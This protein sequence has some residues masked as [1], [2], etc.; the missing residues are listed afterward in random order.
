MRVVKSEALFAS[1][2]LP[3]LILGFGIIVRCVQYLANRSLWLDE[4]ML[5]LNITH[6]T[7]MQLLQPLDYDQ[8]APFAFLMIERASVQ[9]LGNSEYALR[10][11]PLLA[12]IVSLFL[13]FKVAKTVLTQ[14]A[15]IISLMLFV[16]SNP[17]IYYSSEVKQYSSDVTISLLIY[18]LVIRYIREHDFHFWNTVLF[19]IIGAIAIWISHPSIFV[20]TGTGIVLTWF[21]LKRKEWGNIRRL[22]IAC[23]FWALNFA[24]LYFISLRH[25]ATNDV[26]LDYWARNFMPLAPFSLSDVR[27]FIDTFFSIFEYPVGLAFAGM[28]SLSFLL[29]CRFFLRSHKEEFFLFALPIFLA[30][31]ASGFKQYPFE[32]RLLLFL[33]PYMLIFIAQG[34]DEIIE[35]IR[36]RDTAVA[37]AFTVL[38]LLH[39]GLF[40]GYY[41]I[42]PYL[43]E[44]IRP[45]VNY[46]R[47]RY[48]PGD[49]MYLY[50]GALYAFKYYQECYGLA[51]EAYIIGHDMRQWQIHLDDLHKLSGHPRVWILFSHVSTPER[52]R[53]EEV[54]LGQL[55]SMGTRLAALKQERAAVYLYDLTASAY[56]LKLIN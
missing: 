34:A 42:K 38:L 31:L 6:R 2:L 28:G 17:L 47:D 14:K 30:L 4:S 7:F 50:H 41:L 32:G 37:L 5:A 44:E 15:F 8:G 23:A 54:I 55:D 56:P 9:L 11:F 10:L 29:G 20:L 26:L 40:A 22:S 45:V 19:G 24:V 36:P 43:R 1:P 25:L 3:R 13:F 21:Y 51:D 39:P 16:F 27:W 49:V 53:E 52:I 18:L 48:H 33:V 35:M 12:G 46:V